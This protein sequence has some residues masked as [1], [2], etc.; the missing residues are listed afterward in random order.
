M[1]KETYYSVKRDLLQCQCARAMTWTERFFFCQ[2]SWARKARVPTLLNTLQVRG[3]E[4]ERGREKE[5][6]RER[7]RERERKREREKEKEKEKEGLLGA[8]AY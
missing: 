2:E 4:R 8:I 1:S 6:K 3:G 5:R 7:E